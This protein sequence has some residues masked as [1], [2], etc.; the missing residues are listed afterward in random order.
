M[1]L[2]PG[3][4]DGIPATLVSGVD[5]LGLVYGLL[6]LAE[7]V[8]FSAGPGAGLHVAEAMEEKP[9]NEVRMREPV[10]LQRA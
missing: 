9:A 7:R 4:V 5:E 10:F 8:E 1:R 6:E 3:H 2:T